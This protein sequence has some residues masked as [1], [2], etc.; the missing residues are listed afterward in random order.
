MTR[1]MTTEVDIRVEVLS[2]VGRK[3]QLTLKGEG[4][5]LVGPGGREYINE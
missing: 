4:V 5:T 2:K 1:S 3:E